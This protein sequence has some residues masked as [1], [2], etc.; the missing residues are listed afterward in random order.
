MNISVTDVDHG[1]DNIKKEVRK[2]KKSWTSI[3]F[4]T[5]G[6]DP[7]NDIAARAI[8][9]EFG[10]TI[11]VTKKMRGFFLYKF[12]VALK[13]THIT[14]PERPFMKQ[15]FDK[16]KNKIHDRIIE[17]Y[18]RV[19]DGRN[20]AKQALS[21]LGEWYRALMQLTIRGGNFVANSPL[22]IKAKGSSKPLNDTGEMANSIEHR[23]TIK[24]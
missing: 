14:I 4:F 15:T 7:S 8:V 11:P 24:G 18:N 19:L 3:G 22:T 6:G 1:F 12:G 16:N 21:R 2:F 20:T 5:K 13:K 9:Q 23:E 10:A 17:E